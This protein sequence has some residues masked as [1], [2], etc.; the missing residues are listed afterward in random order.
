M[1]V[2]PASI[3]Q[4]PLDLPPDIAQAN[5]VV[6]H[7]MQV[8]F[9][10]GTAAYVQPELAFTSFDADACAPIEVTVHP[11]HTFERAKDGP[12]GYQRDRPMYPSGS[13]PLRATEITVVSAECNLPDDPDVDEIVPLIPEVILDLNVHAALRMGRPDLDDAERRY[14]KNTQYFF[15]KD[16]PAMRQ[17]VFDLG[18]ET[19]LVA[20]QPP[21]EELR[22]LHQDVYLSSQGCSCMVCVPL[23]HYGPLESMPPDRFARFGWRRP[24]SQ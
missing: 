3:E 16:K 24:K 1:S 12:W 8:L 21:V 18:G 20:Q 22:S 17:D 2:Y 7:G 4:L 5:Q 14:L 15:R 11:D 6:W 19:H 13:F 9:K 10:K 23:D